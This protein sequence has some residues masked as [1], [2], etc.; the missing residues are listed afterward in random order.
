MT[1]TQIHLRRFRPE[2][3]DMEDLIEASQL[4]NTL[5]DPDFGEFQLPRALTEETFESD[6]LNRKIMVAELHLSGASPWVVGGVH[7]DHGKVS[8]M[9]V[10]PEAPEALV[11]IAEYLEKRDAVMIIPDEE[12]AVRQLSFWLKRGWSYRLLPGKFVDS[13]G[14]ELTWRPL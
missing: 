7:F 10:H 4:E 5:E 14:W 9:T 12:P 2:L 13:D 6:E 8:W 3:N 1:Q 11:K